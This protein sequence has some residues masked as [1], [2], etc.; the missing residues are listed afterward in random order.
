MPWI[1]FVLRASTESLLGARSEIRARHPACNVVNSVSVIR[2]QV[3]S[4]TRI[5]VESIP[6]V[7]V[8]QNK[9]MLLLPLWITRY[10]TYVTKYAC[11]ESF[12]Y[13]PREICPRR[14]SRGSRALCRNGH[15]GVYTVLRIIHNAIDQRG[16]IDFTAPETS[17]G[18]IA[19]THTK[20]SRCT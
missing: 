15:R 20:R 7:A 13:S 14:N 10:D 8:A 19:L 18:L 5:V 11:I 6:R 16:K 17:F 1:C 12:G 9:T 2:L 3:G 4:P